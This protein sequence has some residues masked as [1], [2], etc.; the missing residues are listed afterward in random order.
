MAAVALVASSVLAISSRISD[1][2]QLMLV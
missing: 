1:F 2:E